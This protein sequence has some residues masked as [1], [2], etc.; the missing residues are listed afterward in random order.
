[1]ASY[2]TVIN[3]KGQSWG[4]T[5]LTAAYGWVSHQFAAC[6]EAQAQAQA[7]NIARVHGG[8]VQPL[9]PVTARGVR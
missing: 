3:D 7:Y 8:T 4:R 6:F 2:Y 9:I 5:S 1:M